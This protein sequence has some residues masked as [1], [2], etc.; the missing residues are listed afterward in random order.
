MRAP[1]FL[2]TYTHS[3]KK[4]KIL[5]SSWLTCVFREADAERR[6]L[7]LLCK[8]ILLVEE[9][10]DGSVNEELVV[11]DG[12]KQHQ[13]LVHAILQK[14]TKETEIDGGGCEV[15]GDEEEKKEEDEEER[16]RWRGS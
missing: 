16:R 3:T 10:D 8:Q 13:G 4:K 7:D 12:V 9:E 1:I 2:H 14:R 6:L 11:A 15:G 5:P